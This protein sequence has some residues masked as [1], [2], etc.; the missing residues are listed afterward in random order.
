MS[1]L[2]AGLWPYI[3]SAVAALVAALGPYAKGRADVSTKAEAKDAAAYRDGRERMDDAD[4]E[5]L[6]ADPDAA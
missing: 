3:T 5:N 1:A 2:L 4:V 6:G